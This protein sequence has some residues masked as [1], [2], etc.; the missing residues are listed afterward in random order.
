M[1]HYALAICE[2]RRWSVVASHSLYGVLLGTRDS[3]YDQ[4]PIKM[5]KILVLE[6]ADQEEIDRRIAELNRKK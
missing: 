5:T 1:T 2:N 4:I 3:L 6:T